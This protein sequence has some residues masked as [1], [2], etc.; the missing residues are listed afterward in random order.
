MEKEWRSSKTLCGGGEMLDQGVHIIDLIRCSVKS[1]QVYVKRKKILEY[2]SRGQSYAILKCQND[3]T[4]LFHVSW[5]NWRNIFSFEIF[6]TEG[7]LLVTGLVVATGAR[8]LN[9]VGAGL[10]AADQK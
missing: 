7:Y 1:H 5:T 10:K 2:R 4:A 8:H 6:G 3:V 9:S